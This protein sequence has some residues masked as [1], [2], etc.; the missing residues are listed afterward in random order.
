[1]EYRPLEGFVFAITPFNF[2]S[3]ASNLNMTPALMGNTTI[4][5]PSTTAL[6]SN[7]T[8]MRIFMEAG[9]P[10]GVVNFLPGKGSVISGV[11]LKD[12]NFNAI[13]FTGST[14]TF[15]SLWKTTG[16]NL[17]MYKAYPRLVGETGGKDFIF[18]H[19][20]ADPQE[21][22]VA[23]V[24]GAF[25]Y[26]GQ[27]CSAASRAYIPASMWNDVKNRVGDMMS[28]IKMGDVKDFTNYVNAV[29]DEVPIVPPFQTNWAK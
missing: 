13:H 7:Y 4:W 26:Q 9:L 27:K 25:E 23:I 17:D 24:R 15:K 10:N 28:T 1:M 29:I 18:V 6:L 16:Q 3:I 22:A 11:A 20:S 12:K 2:T 21:V 8:D 14:A 19:N 5:K